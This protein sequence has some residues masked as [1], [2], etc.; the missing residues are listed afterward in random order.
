MPH[1]SED[2]VIYRKLGEIQ[3]Q[4]GKIQQS[5]ADIHLELGRRPSTKSLSAASKSGAKRGSRRASN[6]ARSCESGSE[7]A[8]DVSNSDRCSPRSSRRSKTKA[9]FSEHTT[10]SSTVEEDVPRSSKTVV[11]EDVKMGHIED[12]FSDAAESSPKKRRLTQ[13][14]D[15]ERTSSSN[16]VGVDP[17]PPRK[18]RRLVKGTRPSQK[19]KVHDNT[20]DSADDDGEPRC[21][22][23]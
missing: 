14:S 21:T 4:L 8:S 12:V 13:V 22:F 19:P 18:L 16:E 6:L 15:S 11:K 23:R 10:K 17:P 1:R 7:T 2:T 20:S 5:L 3:E 9:D